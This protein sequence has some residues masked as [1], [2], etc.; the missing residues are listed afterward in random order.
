LVQNVDRSWRNPN[1][2]RWHGM[3]WL[4]DHGAALYWHHAAVVP[5]DAARRPY[6]GASDHVLLPVAGPL[7]EAH[8][9]LAPLIIRETLESVVSLVPSSWLPAEDR[10]SYVEVLLDR[11]AVPHAWL[12]D[13]EVHRAQ[14]V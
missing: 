3:L 14:R 4:I 5:A 10:E 8:T 13:V 11:V 2:L 6:P 12:D 1:L 7:G 9:A